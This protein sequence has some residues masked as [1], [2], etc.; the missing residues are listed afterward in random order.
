MLYA[1]LEID[2][3]YGHEK[4]SI[5]Y[6]YMTAAALN[7]RH[8]QLVLRSPAFLHEEV[9]PSKY[10][11]DGDNISPPLAI[12]VLPSRTASLV[13]IMDDP[14][15]PQG[16]WDHWVVFNIPP[17]CTRL[18]EG[19][20]V[21]T[22]AQEGATSW[23]TTSYGGPCPPDGEHR[24]LFCVY[25]LDTWLRLPQGSSKKEVLNAMKGHIL[26]STTLM[27]RYTRGSYREL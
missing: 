14:D 9:I 24:Y 3:L 11:C 20:A 8:N 12:D 26:D 22:L 13:L 2:R 6:I 25:A 10:T 17:T 4:E 16:T 23:G 15:A 7:R 5:L 19:M 21:S 18:S 1:T 27:G